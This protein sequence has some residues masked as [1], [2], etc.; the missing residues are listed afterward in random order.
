MQTSLK[1][2]VF[3]LLAILALQVIFAMRTKAPTADE[4]AHHVANGYSYLLTGNFKMNPAS[5]PLPRM[6]TAIPFLFLKAK[7]PLDHESW[8]KGDSPEFARQFFYRY[9]QNADQLIFW[10]RI[11][12]VILSLLFAFSVFK[13]A[14]SLFGIG[15]AFSSLIL[16]V[17]CPDI[18]AHSGLATADLCVA[19]FFFLTLINFGA[20]LKSPSSSKLILTGILAGLCFLS[21]FSAILLFP[22]LLLIGF[23][24]K[25]RSL[26]SPLRILS[27]LCI[28]FFTVWA[29][30]FF[31][32]KPLL[33]ETPDPPKKI[34]FIERIGGP[35]FVK[36]AKDVPI[37]LSTFSAAMAS[38][39]Y[40]RSKGTQAYLMGEWSRKGW[41]YYYFI[42]F[43]LKN[44]I[45]F[46]LLSF[47]SLLLIWKMK[48]DRITTLVLGIPI[49]FFFVATL[50]DKAQAGIRYFL[51]IYPFFMLLAGNFSARCFRKTFILKL[52]IISLYIWHAAEAVLIYPHYLSYFNEFIGGPKNGYKYLRDSNL[53]WGQDLKALA[54]FVHQKGYPD[55]ALVYPWSADPAYY[56]ISYH[57]PSEEE[58]MQPKK[59]VYVISAHYLEAYPWT[60][61]HTPTAVIGYSIF[62]YDFR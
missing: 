9:N 5:P 22:I 42:A 57:K 30:Y 32:V 58:F 34:A 29:G 21:K 24:S 39:V 52:L 38:M 46:V 31:E 55:I 27:F 14:Q 41:W 7:L 28:C 4:L 33:K 17:F 18:L 10:A 47:F 49:L 11:P 53:D 50:Q 25:K 60:L 8:K 35:T 37:P 3:A 15:A 12:I 13:W 62:V 6:L 40:T 36:I 54:N 43:A 23:F 19:L 26:I 45:P 44:T 59:E 61:T 48:L 20:Y 2:S 56:K 51:P 1:V 16:F